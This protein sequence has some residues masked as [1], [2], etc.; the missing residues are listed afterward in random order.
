MDFLICCCS[1]PPRAGEWRA[2]T[3]HCTHKGCVVG[4]NV[5]AGEWQCPCHGSKFAADGKVVAGPADRPLS[6]APT[7]VDGDSL[8]IDMPA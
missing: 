5:T 8:V 4:W 3:A 1:H 2:I 7:R 6:P